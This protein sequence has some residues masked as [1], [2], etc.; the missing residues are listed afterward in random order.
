[1][2]GLSVLMFRLMK[3]NYRRVFISQFKLRIIFE[4]LRVLRVLIKTYFRSSAGYTAGLKELFAKVD[5]IRSVSGVKAGSWR[6]LVIMNSKLVYVFEP[7]A[8]IWNVRSRC[9]APRATYIYKAHDQI[10]ICTYIRT[11]SDRTSSLPCDVD[12]V[13]VMHMCGSCGSS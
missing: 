13:R 8:Y 11:L 6:G 10:Y 7:H 12:H 1:M 5:R 3:I 4:K 9:C 2:T